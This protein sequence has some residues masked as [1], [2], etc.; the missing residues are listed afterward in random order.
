MES[1]K[2]IKSIKRPRSD[3]IVEECYDIIDDIDDVLLDAMIK[4]E[5][6]NCLYYD[7]NIVKASFIK[8]LNNNV[9]SSMSKSIKKFK[10]TKDEC[11]DTI[12]YDMI[13]K[14]ERKSC[15]YYDYDIIKSSF[16]ESLD[17]NVLGTMNRCLTCG[18]DIGLNNPRQL[19]GKTDCYYFF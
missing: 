14:L 19:C 3:I 5:D 7:Y 8:S 13:K 2:N 18:N 10:D 16:L 9:V 4:L 6:N 1:N 15:V 17:N 12:L 11:I